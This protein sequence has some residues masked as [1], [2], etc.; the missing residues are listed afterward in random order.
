MP[1]AAAETVENPR[2]IA[3][4]ERKVQILGLL[5]WTLRKLRAETDEAG[6]LI[7]TARLLIGEFDGLEDAAIAMDRVLE[8]LDFGGGPWSR[9]ILSE[10]PEGEAHTIGTEHDF[11]R[12]FALLALDRIEPG[13]PAEISPRRWLVE[14]HDELVEALETLT[15][16]ELAVLH[17]ATAIPAAQSAREEGEVAEESREETRAS[18]AAHR[19]ALIE[20]LQLARA[21]QRDIDARQTR[22]TPL[23]TEKVEEFVSNIRRGW[24]SG[25][26]GWALCRFVGAIADSADPLTG[27][28][29]WPLRDQW[30]A[31]DMFFEVSR[32]GGLDSFARDIGRA[33]ADDEMLAVVRLLPGPPLMV[34]NDSPIR[35]QVSAAISTLRESGYT[36]SVILAPVDWRV[37]RD[38]LGEDW[39]ARQTT[40]ENLPGLPE[41]AA[42]WF[43]GR[44]EGC[45]VIDWPGIP[46]AIYALDLARF[47]RFIEWTQENGPLQVRVREYSTDEAIDLATRVPDLFADETAR[48]VQQRAERV[49]ENV[50]LRVW[51][52]IRLERTDEAAVAVVPLPPERDA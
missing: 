19:D 2:S 48:T 17:P 52:R 16:N 6:N 23:N 38:L 45:P 8:A 15:E 21:R 1:E 27:E 26:L 22:E 37:E 33:T 3:E 47:A 20:A 41:A 12:A 34:D 29:L 44:I 51:T 42:H 40:A 9:W 28:E 36:P 50:L 25:R 43:R 14:R 35:A 5:M 30:L 11:T 46:R 32:W 10:L 13:R 4:R 18:V 24:E 31:R 7:Q 49:L 39:I